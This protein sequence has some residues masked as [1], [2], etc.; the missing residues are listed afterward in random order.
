MLQCG[1]NGKDL[2]GSQKFSSTAYSS[3]HVYVDYLCEHFLT[4]LQTIQMH[5]RMASVQT[6]ATDPLIH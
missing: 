3:Y 1:C 5:A 2:I 6:K 4:V